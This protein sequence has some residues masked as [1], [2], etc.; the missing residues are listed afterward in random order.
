MS[1]AASQQP[2]SSPARDTA[3][4]TR[5]TAWL[6]LRYRPWLFLGTVLFRGIDDLVPFLNGLI[7]K[8]FFDTITGDAPA[9]F[10]AWTL[11]AFYVII[12]LGDRGVLFVA[13]MIG[14]RWWYTVT[15]LLRK[16]LLTAVLAIRN[17]LH[18]A[19]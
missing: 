6:L 17:P 16:N 4:A 8:A 12:E 1:E 19:G 15:S 2:T 18:V 10:T 9:G 11:V 5:R 7:M 3:P 14:M 13:A